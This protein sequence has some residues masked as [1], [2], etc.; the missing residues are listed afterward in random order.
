VPDRLLATAGSRIVTVSSRGHIDRIMQFD[1]LHFER[2]YRA[3]PAADPSAQGGEYYGP[4]GRHDTGYPVRVES[5][6]R[7]HDA[8]AQGRLWAVSEQ[9]TGVSYRMVPYPEAHAESRQG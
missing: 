8:V 1:D 7:S 3:S 4:Q 2:G 5:S 9:L 6:D